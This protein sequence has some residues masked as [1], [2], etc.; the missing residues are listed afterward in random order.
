MTLYELHKDNDLTLLLI[1]EGWLFLDKSKLRSLAITNNI[2]VDFSKRLLR[3]FSSSFF[4][5]NLKIMNSSYELVFFLDWDKSK[6]T[7]FAPFRDTTRPLLSWNQ[8]SLSMFY[9]FV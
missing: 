7:F 3:C 2:S 5:H 6:K 1:S 4:I 9:T 8:G